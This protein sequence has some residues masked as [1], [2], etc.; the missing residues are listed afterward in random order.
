MAKKLQ[1]TGGV[2]SE[3]E[4]RQIVDEYLAKNP[5]VNGIVDITLTADDSGDTPDTPDEPGDFVI[6]NA[7][8]NSNP[9]AV[10][11]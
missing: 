4:A 7:T 2:L 8:D 11:F 5:P 10:I 3:E 9:V 6:M 1:F